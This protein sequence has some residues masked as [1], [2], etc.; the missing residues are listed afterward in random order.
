VLG[1]SSQYVY[2]DEQASGTIARGISQAG[3][4]YPY[5]APYYNVYHYP[6]TIGT[7]WSSTWTWGEEAL[8]IPITSTRTNEVVGWG[9][10]TVPLGGPLPCL[11]MRTQLTDYA[12]FLGVPVV[13]ESFKIYEWIVPNIGSVA[14]IQSVT[15]ESNWM[16]SQASAFFRLYDSN[17]GGDLIP[18]TIAGVTVLTDTPN[19]GPY[20]VNA[21]ITDASGIDSAAIYYSIA[22]GPWIAAGPTQIAGA[23]YTFSLPAPGGVPIRNIRYYIWARDDSPNLNVRTNPTNAPTGN[24]SFNWIND[25]APPVFTGVTVWPSPTNFNGPYPVSATI[26]D[27]NG[28]LFASLFYRFGAGTWNEILPDQVVGDV[29]TFTIPAISSSTIIRYYLEAVDNSGFFNTGSFPAAG[30]AGPIVFNAVFTVPAPP[31]APANVTIYYNLSDV[32]LTWQPVTL[33]INNNP[34]VISEY[35]IYR[36]LAG[37][38]SDHVF[39]LATP[40]TTFTDVGATGSSAK[41]FYTVK[42]ITP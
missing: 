38:G 24:Y 6:M 33:D 37:N 21:T 29:Y 27:D 9:T 4:I 8:G 34:V 25:N 20:A 39:L 2:E 18:P 11:V 14:T 40:N 36:G 7:P 28:V 12:E 23:L 42:A 3:A 35:R 17:L 26:T 22:N 1:G 10:V 32:V 19:P 31:R 30:M 41:Y 5:A 13:D 15:H 16:Y